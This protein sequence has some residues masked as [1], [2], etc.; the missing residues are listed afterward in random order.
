M[1]IAYIVPVVDVGVSFCFH[2][3]MKFSCLHIREC[4][5]SNKTFPCVN[6]MSDILPF[7]ISGKL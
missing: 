3:S 5:L 7:L 1:G 2:L 6:F 4:F